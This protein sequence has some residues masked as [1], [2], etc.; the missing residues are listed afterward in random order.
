MS[1]GAAGIAPLTS[2]K[3]PLQPWQ[4]DV[5]SWQYFKSV[6]TYEPGTGLGLGGVG[7]TAVF[8]CWPVAGGA[9]RA[10]R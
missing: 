1:L 10:G 9:I 8:D 4:T 7:R 6:M 3:L 5:L 2:P